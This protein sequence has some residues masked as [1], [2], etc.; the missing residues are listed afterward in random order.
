MLFTIMVMSK[1]GITVV[2]CPKNIGY[3][4]T[5]VFM[6][7]ICICVLLRQYVSLCYSCLKNNLS[8]LLSFLVTRVH[9]KV[10]RMKRNRN[11]GS[12]KEKTEWRGSQKGHVPAT[13][14]PRALL[15][16]LATICPLTVMT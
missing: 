7:I 3:Y 4:G 11:G 5:Q 14:P 8:S 13:N 2:Q 12:V 1:H 9:R 10:L 6:Y 16:S 15:I